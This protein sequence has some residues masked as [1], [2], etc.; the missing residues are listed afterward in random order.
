[1]NK[2]IKAI[3]DTREIVIEEHFRGVGHKWDTTSCPLC[4]Y[5]GF[6]FVE[7][8]CKKCPLDVNYGCLELARYPDNDIFSATPQNINDFLY[9][10][11][12]YYEG[13]Q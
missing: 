7:S 13:G 5:S 2:L 11:Q 1:M 6:N 10:L 9:A 3:K 4:R 12:K 8:S